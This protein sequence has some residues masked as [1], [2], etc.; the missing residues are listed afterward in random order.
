[1]NSKF[2]S[3]LSLRT[4]FL[5]AISVVVVIISVAFSFTLLQFIELLEDEMI[6]RTLAR[7]MESF[8]KDIEHHPEHAPPSEGGLKGYVVRTPEDAAKLPPA[9]QSIAVGVHEYVA[10]DGIEQYVARRD[11]GDTRLYLEIDMKRLET[12]EA[13]ITVIG[14]AS[15]ALALAL[16]AF[17]ATLLAR[18]VLRPVSKLAAEVAALD[19][20]QRKVQLSHNI[21]DR[22]VGIIATAF[23][24]YLV[25]LDTVLEREHAFTEDA[26]HELRTPLSIIVS[27]AQLLSEE[28]QLSPLGQERITRIRRACGQMQTLIEALLFLAREDEALPTQSCALDEIVREAANT[29]SV[30][31]ADKNVGLNVDVQPVV[32]IAP[33]G[34]V[35]CVVNNL[36]LNAINFTQQGLIEVKLTSTELMVR[37]TGIGIAPTELT[38]IFERRYRGSQSRGL[39]LG[40]YLV[41]RICERLGW[42]IQADSSQGIGTTFRIQLPTSHPPQSERAVASIH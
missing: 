9:L 1:M 17:V 6:T 11:I 12:L 10:D 37:D 7:E 32:V 22:E 3:R 30:M 13:N 28:S 2:S 27:S 24:N 35:V 33:A 14:F 26:S 18:A 36:L 40:L 8:V 23:D 25:R 21:A 34:M 16:A 19:P 38:H 42:K 29:I 15:G 41:N 39:G 20:R 4:R 5:L 31:A